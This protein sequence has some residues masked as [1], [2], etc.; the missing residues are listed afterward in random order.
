[1]AGLSVQGAIKIAG[2]KFEE[3]GPILI[4]HWGLSG[5]AALRLSA[6]AAE[7]FHQKAYRCAIL[8]RWMPAL[9]EE[10][11]R[12]FLLDQKNQHPKRM[13]QKYP[14]FEIPKRLWIRLCELAAIEEHHTYGETGNKALRKLVELCLRTPMEM[15]G[16][17]TFKEEFVTSGGVAL[18]EVLPGSME[19]KFTPG[20]FFAGEILNVDGVTGGF[21]FQAAWS[22]A[23]AAAAAIAERLNEKSRH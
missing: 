3:H 14:H 2:T 6:F 1:M 21:N 11:I 16:K 20:L 18:E 5:P 13:I 8:V 4:T 9:D 15:E 22:T 12:N 17:T 10:M 23:D 7:H 19:S